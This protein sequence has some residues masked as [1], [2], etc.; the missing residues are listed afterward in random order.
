M[1]DPRKHILVVDDEGV[2]LKTLLRLLSKDYEVHG[3]ESLEGARAHL[4]TQ[5]PAALLFDLHLKDAGPDAILETLAE[6]QL[7]DC[8]VFMS[9]GRMGTEDDSSFS[10]LPGP[11][12]SKPFNPVQLRQLLRGVIE[13]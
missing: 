8:T 10:E 4:S 2:V 5:R 13:S 3:A 1:A 9:G 11:L 6:F 7:Q 12:L